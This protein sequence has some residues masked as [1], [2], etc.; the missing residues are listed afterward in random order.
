MRIIGGFLMEQAIVNN[1]AKLPYELFKN[2]K[3]KD[4]KLADI[5][6]YTFM[7]DR[8][9]LSK[10]NGWINEDGQVYIKYT[11]ASLSEDTR[12]SE[13]TVKRSLKVLK[14]LGLIEVVSDQIKN[15]PNAYVV[16]DVLPAEEH[17]DKLNYKTEDRSVKMNSR[18][19]KMNHES[20]IINHTYKNNIITY[21]NEILNTH[22]RDFIYFREEFEN[23]SNEGID[24]LLKGWLKGYEGD[25]KEKHLKICIKKWIEG[26]EER[27]TDPNG[28]WDKYGK[29]TRKQSG[30]PIREEINNNKPFL[31]PVIDGANKGNKRA[32]ARMKEYQKEGKVHCDEEGIWKE[33][34]NALDTRSKKEL[35]PF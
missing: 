34:H 32:I 22:S 21:V 4:M 28:F 17:E 2:E 33:V 19:V 27:L 3:Y 20:E 11:A 6:I 35:L 29:T 16:F 23:M 10:A 7:R 25:Y 30:K 31:K 18:G 8:I 26:E 24:K 1:W 9:S 5:I 13:S 15:K 12:I 14:S